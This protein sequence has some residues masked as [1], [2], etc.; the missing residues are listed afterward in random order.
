LTLAIHSGDGGTGVRRSS[1]WPFRLPLAEPDHHELMKDM[2]VSEYDV[3]YPKTFTI[4]VVQRRKMKAWA[5]RSEIDVGVD[6][7]CPTLYG[8]R[9]PPGQGCIAR[10]I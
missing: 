3:G 9:P 8:K 6:I 2:L 10:H 1:R 4:D 5:V 7:A